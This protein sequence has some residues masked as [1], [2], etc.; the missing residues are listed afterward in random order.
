MIK[1]C[2]NQAV[3]GPFPQL[4]RHHRQAALCLNLCISKWWL[5]LNKYSKVFELILFTHTGRCL[6]SSDNTSDNAKLM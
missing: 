2:T 3:H 5:L 1:A 4:Q 6:T